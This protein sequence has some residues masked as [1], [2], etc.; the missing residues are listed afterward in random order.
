MRTHAV[1]CHQTYRPECTR[2]HVADVKS[3]HQKNDGGPGFDVI[4]SYLLWYCTNSVYFA[5][6]FHQMTQTVHKLNVRFFSFIMQVL[7]G[8]RKFTCIEF[9]LFTVNLLY[10]YTC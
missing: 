3:R 10:I 6:C 9:I 7:F 1:C 4:A 2:T 5:H 8:S